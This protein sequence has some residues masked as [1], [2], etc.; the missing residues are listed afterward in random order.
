MNFRWDHKNRNL[1]FNYRIYFLCVF[2]ISN[3]SSHFVCF[4]THYGFDQT[5]SE[6]VQSCPSKLDIHIFRYP[7][8]F[9][10]RSRW[11][12][13]EWT[14]THARTSSPAVKSWNEHYVILVFKFII[15]FSLWMRKVNKII[16]PCTFSI[17]QFSMLEKFKTFTNT[18]ELKM[19]LYPVVLH[20]AYPALLC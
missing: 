18:L 15:Q 12:L 2:I 8:R 7:Q 3:H 4:F 19:H 5:Q 14:A 20:N 16:K 10:P 9:V 1:S 6:P 13:R 11:A 17:V